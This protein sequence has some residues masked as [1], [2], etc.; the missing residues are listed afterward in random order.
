MG[1]LFLLISLLFAVAGN[2]SVKLSKGF[3]KRMASIASFLLYGV[4]LYFLTLSVRYMAI[5]IAYAIWSGVTIASTT[6]IGVLFF[7]E[8]ISK[9]KIGS[10]VL[11]IVGVII[12]KL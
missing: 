7:Q 12:V 6:L 9:G 3:Q 5:S 1:T 2:T 8:K 4:C 10:I 11:I